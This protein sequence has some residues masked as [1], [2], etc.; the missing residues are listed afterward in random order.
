MHWVSSLASAALLVAAQQ[1]P[2]SRQLR[3][4]AVGGWDVTDTADSDGGRLVELTR[5]GRT[6]SLRY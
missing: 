6:F 2:D 3:R 1:G 4:A 5:D